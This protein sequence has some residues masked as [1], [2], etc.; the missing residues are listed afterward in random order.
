MCL[1]IRSASVIR[2]TNVFLS[3]YAILLLIC[4]TLAWE[5]LGVMEAGLNPGSQKWTNLSII[6][7]LPTDMVVTPFGKMMLDEVMFSR[8]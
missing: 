4:G 6:T 3:I 1:R 8:G 2:I 7:R 5:R